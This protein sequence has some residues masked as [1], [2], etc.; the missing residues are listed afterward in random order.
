MSKYSRTQSPVDDE[1]QKWLSGTTTIDYKR[2]YWLISEFDAPLWELALGSKKIALDWNVPLEDGSRLTDSKNH[3]L[4]ELFKLWMCIQGHTSLTG[5]SIYSRGTI[6]KKVGR[7]GRIIDYFLI[8]TEYFQLG[9]HGLSLVTSSDVRTLYVTLA[10]S[11]ETSESIYDFN[12]TLR[13][14]LLEEGRKLSADQISQAIS[15]Q[16]LV[17][18]LCVPASDRLLFPDDNELISARCYLQLSGHYHPHTQQRFIAFRNFKRLIQKLYPNALW[19]TRSI[20]SRPDELWLLA[21]NCYFREYAGVPVATY[22]RE[23][24]SSQTVDYWRD[25]VFSLLPLSELGHQVPREPIS[26]GWQSGAIKHLNLG[27]PGRFRTLPAEWYLDSLRE[28][29]EFTLA[30]GEDLLNS[31]VNLVSTAI[32]SGLSLLKFVQQHGI[33]AHLTPKLRE[34]GVK[35]WDVGSSE[36]LIRPPFSKAGDFPSGSKS[37]YFE[38]VRKNE[39][40]YELIQVLY[41]CIEICVGLLCARRISE[42]LNLLPGLALD[43]T[44]QN[45]VFGNMKTGADGMREMTARPA[46]PIVDTMIGMLERFQEELRKHGVYESTRPLFARPSRFNFEFDHSPRT[47]VDA[48]DL[49]CD[50]FEAPLDEEGRRYY[51]RQ[52]QLRR[53]FPMLFFWHRSYKGLDTLTWFL[54]QSDSEQIYRYVLDSTPG[55]V[56]KWSKAKYG[57]QMLQEDPSYSE[58]L[59]GLIEEHFGTRNFS[60]LDFEE[61]EEY[62]H[63]LIEDSTVTIEPQF[64]RTSEGTDFNVITHVKRIEK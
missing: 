21:S 54:G 61:L 4:L 33:E 40:L 2:P 1:L 58:D 20:N 8:R 3:S 36:G 43:K 14:Y 27:S 57:A 23:L 49:F 53:G 38:R 25:T 45:L 24:P 29:I 30:Y 51:I 44:R 50:Y 5:G 28:S 35:V 52:H 10:S 17:E 55:D 26:E 41:G 42:L 6:A 12:E 11:C 62:I 39:G 22:D 15:D 59:A 56:L 46:P 31:Y 48:T 18:E 7:V 60:V 64:F 9:Q 19:A 63:D 32:K 16:P 47:Y 37:A 13:K 34:L